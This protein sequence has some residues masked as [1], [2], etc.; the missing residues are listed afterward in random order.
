MLLP[1]LREALQRAG[2]PA[3][4]YASYGNAGFAN[5]TDVST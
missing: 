3:R 1:R 2:D 4:A 5:T